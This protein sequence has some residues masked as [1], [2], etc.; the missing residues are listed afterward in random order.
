MVWIPF[1]EQS[2]AQKFFLDIY[3][4]R[5]MRARVDPLLWDL[6]HFN[7]WPLLSVDLPAYN[8]KAQSWMERY[9]LTLIGR[10]Y[11]ASGEDQTDYSQWGAAELREHFGNLP[12]LTQGLSWWQLKESWKHQETDMLWRTAELLETLSESTRPKNS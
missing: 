7:S 5:T 3:D 9:I 2:E 8:A 10:T 6:R 11:R 12:V 4:G 1:H